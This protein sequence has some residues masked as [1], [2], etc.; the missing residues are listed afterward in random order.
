MM[1]SIKRGLSL[2]LV[3]VML[4]GTLPVEALATGFGTLSPFWVQP[5]TSTQAETEPVY[6]EVAEGAT[7]ELETRK[8]SYAN[9]WRI[10]EGGDFASVKKIN[11]SGNGRVTGIKAGTARVIHTYTYGV[12]DYTEVFEIT[13]TAA[14]PSAAP[15]TLEGPDV[16]MVGDKILQTCKRPDGQTIEV[17]EWKS[18]NED[19]ATTSKNTS[20]T[21]E[22]SFYVKG[23]SE[24]VVTITAKVR[25]NGKN[26]TTSKQITVVAKTATG[27]DVTGAD[28]VE[29]GHSIDLTATPSPDGTTLTGVTWSSSDPNVASVDNN[30]HVT[31]ITAGTATITVT[32]TNSNNQTLTTQHPITVTLPVATAIKITDTDKNEITDQPS[33]EKDGTIDLDYV[34]T[35]EGAELRDVAWSHGKFGG[36]ATVDPATGIVTGVAPGSAV[37]TVGGYNS[38]DEYISQTL[39]ITVTAEAES[40]TVTGDN[41]IPVGNSANLTASAVPQGAT[42]PETLTWKSS[43][44]EIATVDENGRVTGMKDGTVTIT[45]SGTNGKN[46]QVQGTKD[47]RVITS[48]III[49]GPTEVEQFSK[50]TLDY[51][52][53]PENLGLTNIR[54]A[55]LTEGIAT[56][57]QSTGEVTGVAQ[58][59]ATIRVHGTNSNNVDVTADYEVRVTPPVDTDG[60]EF[61]YLKT[62]TSDP[63]SNSTDQWGPNLGSGRVNLNNAVFVNDKNL[64]L[65]GD[66]SRVISWPSGYEGGNVP[67]GPEGSTWDVILTAFLEE[68]EKREDVQSITLIPYK[69]SNNGTYHVDSTVKVTMKSKHVATY[70]LWDAGDTEY[71]WKA[72][73]ELRSGNTTQPNETLAA[74]DR[75]KQLNGRTYRLY[76]WYTNRNLSGSEVT[77]PYTVTGN[78]DFY[79]K[80]VADYLV[81]YDLNG[82]T[83]ADP[84]I[85]VSNKAAGDPVDVNSRVPTREGYT[86]TGWQYGGTTYHGGDTFT[87]PAADVTLTAQ[88]EAESYDVS[89]NWTGNVP[90]GKLFDAAG[91]EAA[92]PTLPTGS[93]QQ[94]NASVT[95]DPTYTS[96]TVYHTHD[97]YGNVNGT[98]A[99]SG[100]S[101]TDAAI[102]NGSFTMP[103]KDVKIIGSWTYADQEVATHTVS[104]SWENAPTGK[105]AQTLPTDEGRYVKNQSYTVDSKFTSETVVEHK[106]AYGNVD[107]TWTFSGWTDPSSGTMVEG[108]VTITGE[109]TYTSKPVTKYTVSYDWGTNVPEGVTLPS[110]DGEYVKGQ[111]YTVDDTYTSTSTVDTKDAYGNVDGKWTFSGW[112][113]PNNGTMVE[114]GVTITGEWKYEPVTVIDY[115]VTYSWTGEPDGDYAQ[116]LPIDNHKYVKNETYL[117]DDTFTSETVVEHKDAYGNVDGKW[118]FS[119]WTDP[120]NGTMVEGGVTITGEWTLTPVDVAHWMITYKFTGEVPAEKVDK[121][122]VDEKDYTNNESYKVDTTVKLGDKVEI[123]DGF[124]N[125][126]ETY[127]FQGWNAKDGNI[128]SDLTIEGAWTKAETPAKTWNIT[129]VDGVEEAE[130]FADDVHNG[131]T[132]NAFTPAFQGSTE[133]AGYQF[134]Y[135][136]SDVEE[137]SFTA[138]DLAAKKVTA[139]VIYTAQW[140]PIDY[141]LIYDA[142]GGD[143]APVDD[144][145]YHITETVQLS[146]DQKPTHPAIEGRNV[147][148]MGWTEQ[149][150]T[151]I[152]TKDDAAPALSTEVTFGTGDITVYAVWGY[153]EDGDNIPDVTEH[154]I[155]F[156]A[157]SRQWTYNGRMQ[158]FTEYSNTALAQGDRIAALTY[159]AR[160]TDAS[161]A[162]YNGTF[163][164]LQIVNGEGTDVTDTYFVTYVPGT[165]TINQLPITIQARSDSKTYDGR[166]LTNSDSDLVSGRLA[167]GH[168]YTAAV[169]GTI[170]Y[171]GSVENVPSNARILDANWNDVTRNYAITYLNGTLTVTDGTGEGETPIDPLVVRKTHGNGTA[172]YALGQTV[173]FT[174]TVTNVYNEAKNITLTEREGMTLSQS[175]FQNVAPGA[176]VTATVTYIVTEA[177]V[178]A[179]TIHNEVNAAFDGGSTFTADDDVPVQVPVPSLL[180]EKNVTSTAVRYGLG[181][182][183]NYSIR[184]TNNGNVTLTNVQVTDP[185]TGQSWVV[186]SMAPGDVVNFSTSHV[187]TAMDVERGSVSNTATATGTS[188]EGYP[189]PIVADTETVDTVAPIRSMEIEKTRITET[190][191]VGYFAVGQTID[192]AISVTNTGNVN[193]YNVLVTDELTGLSE[194]IPTLAPGVTETIRTSYEVR[195]ADAGSAGIVNTAVA[196]VPDGPTVTDTTPPAPVVGVFTLTVNYVFADGS[197]AAP[198]AEMQLYGGELYRVKSPTV[199]GFI[200]NTAFV[201]GF[202]PHNDVTWTIVYNAVDVPAAPVVVDT[203]DGPVATEPNPTGGVELDPTNYTLILVEDEETPLAN[204]GLDGHTDCALHFILILAAM[205][206]MM[207]YTRSMK[208]H[209][210]KIQELTEELELEKKHRGASDGTDEKE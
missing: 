153:D 34:I 137:G 97:T 127:T 87:M 2:L 142:N 55:S 122:P 110:D 139:D 120:S 32:G 13:V 4:I 163:S 162:P 66:S 35:P 200:A 65:G 33:I 113:D 106:D 119:G 22:S 118:T 62:P 86:F 27:L 121:E 155:T 92:A 173:T 138:A 16:V 101:T 165:L 158:E 205:V 151:T 208:K 90:A 28:T 185:L 117:V 45:V 67:Q 43:N 19:I 196:S 130:V 77:F 11:S 71:K 63:A 147:V 82:G 58:G 112:T 170:T 202:M 128:T 24:G 79:A 12:T 64:F 141:K 69:I 160:G 21:S 50:I 18:S 159:S 206:V 199:A 168:T 154:Q 70:Y 175:N 203:P 89:Y 8:G 114:G 131:I 96:T 59:T 14:A 93:T 133:R 108:G 179:G 76:S 176:S 26:V 164:G 68:G 107:G 42:L 148:F 78:V 166:A 36:I 88:W 116:T 136:T 191:E 39:R 192:Y 193:L 85:G 23:E 123:R 143:G 174:I 48:G 190:P 74:L 115:S 182:T 7:I 180:V 44:E 46:E 104:Y 84:Q 134:A 201:T 9:D 198:S 105:Y 129:Y 210:K 183:V 29:E 3:V 204:M 38:K 150:D 41:V 132:N 124:G 109:W 20:D 102:T 178:L 145:G 47:I 57:D 189:D 125:V 72:A 52:K 31:G 100:W 161:A 75:T 172:L 169:E 126:I 51:E 195:A 25:I 49:T 171:C 40:L 15:F 149:R 146:T 83:I 209:Q 53:I 135:W 10:D 207:A 60:A 5:G 157:E 99:F 181:D 177:D 6:R 17:R 144:R 152:Y 1:K 98:Y 30:G 94:Y 54:W 80:Y 186:A 197:E 140:T 188:P 194:T 73:E 56:V 111:G 184:V 167:D 187:V 91:N 37:I 95:V 61:Y 81:R 156:S 103:A